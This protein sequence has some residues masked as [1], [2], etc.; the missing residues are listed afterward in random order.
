MEQQLE[1]GKL[2]AKDI[3]EHF[4]DEKLEK[5]NRYKPLNKFAMKGQILF[6]GSSLMERFPVNELQQTLDKKFI[7][8]NRGVGGFVTNEL[9]TAMNTCICD[10]FPSKIF[11]NIGTNDIAS[12]EY[13]QKNLIANYDRIL[14]EIKSQLPHCK[15][16]M[17][18]YYPVN[19]KMDF[20]S[21][22]EETE[23]EPNTR[24]N[25][26]LQE[27]NK[28]LKNLA[29]TYHYQYIDVNDGLVDTTGNL[30]EEYT[31]EGIHL[32]PNAY[33]TILNNLKQYL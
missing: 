1:D 20:P 23:I 33:Y 12:P 10:L 15:V 11:I 8:Y 17:V 22:N 9:L 29:K 26:T 16:Y 24:T 31:V 21:V 2:K 13:I 27:A 7:I 14:K 3:V 32:W 30:K 18:A 25:P 6:V 19:Q 4:D 5:L 28:A